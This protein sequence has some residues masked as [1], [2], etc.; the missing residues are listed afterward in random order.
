MRTIAPMVLFSAVLA[1]A[2]VAQD[3]DST[4]GRFPVLEG[5]YLGQKP[6]AKMPQLFAPGIVSTGRDDLNAVFSADGT[7]FILG[8]RQASAC[9]CGRS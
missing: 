2:L 1:G 8:V 3:L 6:P 9:R 7:E 5:P 4:A